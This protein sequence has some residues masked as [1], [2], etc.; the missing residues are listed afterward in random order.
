MK[1]KKSPTRQRARR[2]TIALQKQVEKLSERERFCLDAY[3]VNKNKVGA[4][5]YSREKE[6]TLHLE[7]LEVMAGKW[8]RTEPVIAY[9]QM[10][11]F[12]I[13]LI[14]ET[15]N[16][17]EDEQSV[18]FGRIAE[19]LDGFTLSED[20]KVAIQAAKELGNLYQLKKQASGSN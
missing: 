11:G 17:G 13:Q 3:I 18:V 5:L 12:E 6:S 7:S 2:P 20:P 9:L 14:E 10:K 1:Q 15:V 4:Y 19:L 16:K 8:F